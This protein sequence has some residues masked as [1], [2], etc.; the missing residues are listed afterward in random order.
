MNDRMRYW[1][2]VVAV[3]LAM[4]AIL[5]LVRAGLATALPAEDSDAVDRIVAA[6]APILVAA[7][8]ASRAMYSARITY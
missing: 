6:R 4:L 5:A 1:I 2:W 8:E 7:L 3:Y